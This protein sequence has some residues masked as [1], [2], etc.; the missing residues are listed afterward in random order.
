MA[1]DLEEDAHLKASF[2]PASCTSSQLRGIF[3]QHNI[4]APSNLKKADLV[5]LFE[6]KV[7]PNTNAYIAQRRVKGSTRGIRDLRTTKK[8]TVPD[9]QDDE[10]DEELGDDMMDVDE[11]APA[12]VKRS[13]AKAPVAA[14]R[15]RLPRSRSASVV[16]SDEEVRP[17]PSLPPYARTSVRT[18]QGHEAAQASESRSSSKGR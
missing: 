2:D 7:R 16:E 5:Q 1:K 17:V 6:T 10:G 8:T 14:R 4:P 9:S 18:G 13:R 15:T 11:P 12:P 3:L